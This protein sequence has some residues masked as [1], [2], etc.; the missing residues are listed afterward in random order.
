MSDESREVPEFYKTVAVIW[1]DED[2][3]GMGLSDLAREAK[4]GGAICTLH[5]M[6]AA[7]PAIDPSYV[8]AEEFFD[9]FPEAPS[10]PSADPSPY[11]AASIRAALAIVGEQ[12]FGEDVDADDIVRSAAEAYLAVAL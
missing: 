10:F 12:G 4:V 11:T 3:S 7:D 1:S 8:G 5:R 9:Y 2:P 6:A